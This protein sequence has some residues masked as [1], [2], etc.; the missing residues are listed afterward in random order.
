MARNCTEV[1]EYRTQCGVLKNRFVERGYDEANLDV[2]IQNVEME[3]R[4][5]KEHTKGIVEKEDRDYRF[6]FVTKFCSMSDNVKKMQYNRAVIKSLLSND[7]AP[8]YTAKQ[9]NEQQKTGSKPI[10]TVIVSMSPSLPF[11]LAQHILKCVAS[12][13]LSAYI[14]AE[15]QKGLAIEVGSELNLKAKFSCLPGLKGKNREPMAVLIQISSKPPLTKASTEDRIVWT[16]WFCRTYKEEDLLEVLPKLSHPTVFTCLLLFLYNGSEAHTAIVGMWFQR[17]FDCCFG[18]LVIS[19]QDLTWLAAIWTGYEVSGSL[20][21]TELVFSVPIEPHMDMSY[22]T[23]A[24]DFKTLWNDIHKSKDKVMLEEVDNLF[25]CLYSHLFRH[26][27][28]H[29]SATQLVT[30]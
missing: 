17:N 2:C 22:A 8:V 5:R 10:F 4:G 18:N 23:P 20:S 3:T 7:L 15:K 13:D 16:G 1:S 30:E 11:L 9:K 19:S 14:A 26:F 6:S 12:D 21:A 27:R 25:L 28:I 24:E 29:L